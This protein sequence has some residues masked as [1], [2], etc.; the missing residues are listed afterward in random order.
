MLRHEVDRRLPADLLQGCAAT[1]ASASMLF[2]GV[3]A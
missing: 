1:S 3:R 2:Y